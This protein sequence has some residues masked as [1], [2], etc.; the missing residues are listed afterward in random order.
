MKSAFSALF[1]SSLLLT[2]TLALAQYGGTAG[3]QATTGGATYQST[4]QP[5]MPTYSKQDDNVGLQG[6]IVIAAERLTGI[7]YDHIS[8]TV[9]TPVG[10]Q[11]TKTSTTTFAVFGNQG[12]G[13][14][15]APRLALDYFVID[16]LS[17]GGSFTYWHRA[18]TLTAPNGGETDISPESVLLFNPRVGF[19]LIFDDTFA[20]WPRAGITYARATQTTKETLASGGSVDLDTTLSSFALSLDV[21]LVI[22]PMEHF[23]FLIGPYLDLGLGGSLDQDVVDTTTG[24]ITTVSGDSKATSVGLT[25]GILGYY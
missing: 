5:G 12:S 17:L 13:L 24:A 19:S 15:T 21:P 6:Q 18:G 22:S 20:L 1:G 25:V 7:F 9:S 11:E 14:T 3:G 4:Y 10:D 23:A 8:E 2:S 16:G